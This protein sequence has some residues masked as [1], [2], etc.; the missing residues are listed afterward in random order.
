MP[1]RVG[2]WDNTQRAIPHAELVARPAVGQTTLPHGV[3]YMR[4]R[5]ER[6]FVRMAQVSKWWRL[7]QQGLHGGVEMSVEVQARERDALSCPTYQEMAR[8]R[9]T[10]DTRDVAQVFIGD[11]TRPGGWLF[12]A[13]LYGA[14]VCDDTTWDGRV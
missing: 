10:G 12:G 8:V 9:I 11:A 1:F 4:W 5:D 3:I 14:L 2:T 7:D 13:R 6:G